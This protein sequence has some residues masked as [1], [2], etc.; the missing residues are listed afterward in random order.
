MKMVTTAL[1][2][3]FFTALI[4]LS[5]LGKISFI[6]GSQ[7]AFFSAS[8]IFT[9][10][11]GAF[12]G[13]FASSVIMLMRLGW[14]LLIYKTISLSFLALCIPGYVAAIYMST[15]SG[16]NKKYLTYMSF[17]FLLP[18]I[19]MFLFI[20]HPVGGQA[21]VYSFYW[22]IPMIITIM[23]R[24]T[25]FAHALASTF[26]AHAVGSVMWLY[27]TSGMT[28]ALWLGLIP[29]VALER[30]AF[31]TGIVAVY[32]LLSMSFTFS[33]SLFNIYNAHCRTIFTHNK[34]KLEV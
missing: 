30:V 31:A 27:T 5:A 6:V 19:C 8:T 14:Q 16:T 33:F 29:L 24:K 18:L 13:A 23:E 21:S 20:V 15:F 7:V 12:C 26:I 17:G 9:P 3:F 28:A 22:F 34:L 1:K 4:K 11:A 32:H 25:L 2:S 10:V